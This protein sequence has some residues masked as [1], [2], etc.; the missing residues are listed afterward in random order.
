MNINIAQLR[1]C[2]HDHYEQIDA[3]GI[4]DTTVG[5]LCSMLD[6]CINRTPHVHLTTCP[7]HPTYN[8]QFAGERGPRM[9]GW[10]L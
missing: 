2:E 6:T 1:L 4:G 7:D 10:Y 9:V 5:T 8:A 3:E